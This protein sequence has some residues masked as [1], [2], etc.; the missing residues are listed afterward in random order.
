VINCIS[1]VI[2]RKMLLHVHPVIGNVLLNKFLRRHR[3]LVN[4]SLQGYAT[5]EEAVILASAVTSRS[6]GL[7][8]RDMFPVMRA[9]SLVI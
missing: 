3:L 9:R 1:V 6:G 8:S 2:V 7:W 4:I 5:I